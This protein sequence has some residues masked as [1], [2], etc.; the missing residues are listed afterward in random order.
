MINNGT[1]YLDDLIKLRKR[2][3]VAKWTPERAKIPVLTVEVIPGIE[4]NVTLLGFKW[5]VT[6]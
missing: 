3:L 1:I 2:D 5:N 6:A 4:S